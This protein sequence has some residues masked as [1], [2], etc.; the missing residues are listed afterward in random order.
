MIVVV[1]GKERGGERGKRETYGFFGFSCDFF[2]AGGVFFFF[3]ECGGGGPCCWL[4]ETRARSTLFLISA[5]K[6]FLVFA[7]AVREID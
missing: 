7:C 2:L 4:F 3:D 1:A 5:E 6:L